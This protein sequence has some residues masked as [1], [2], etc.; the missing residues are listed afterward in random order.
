LSRIR[1]VYTE[2]SDAFVRR[3]AVCPMV[4]MC[5]GD[6]RLVWPAA[7]A[8]PSLPWT[9]STGGSSS[10]RDMAPLDSQL[11][12]AVKAPVVS[13]SRSENKNR[14][15]PVYD[16]QSLIDRPNGITTSIPEV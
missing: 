16:I 1:L 4:R 14:L 2:I 3:R 13:V 12:I 7:A 10:G 6:A 9:G 11:A 5:I 15:S 8:S